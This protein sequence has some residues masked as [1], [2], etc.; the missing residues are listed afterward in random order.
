MISRKKFCCSPKRL[1]FELLK[2]PNILC[3][4]SVKVWKYRKLYPIL[5]EQETY[6][7][8]YI[9]Q[10]VPCLSNSVYWTLHQTIVKNSLSK[11]TRPRMIEHTD[12]HFRTHRNVAKRSWHFLPLRFV[13][14]YINYAMFYERVYV[15]AGRSSL[16]LF[17]ARCRW[18]R[19]EG[20]RHAKSWRGGKNEKLK[21]YRACNHLF[22]YWL[23]TYC[24]FCVK[25]RILLLNKP[26]APR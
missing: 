26:L 6:N 25:T 7:K 12:V 10:S 16:S 2:R 20:E 13:P 18:W 5:D 21:G 4:P 24:I 22:L 9:Q 8:V 1:I 23:I 19:P 17:Q 14:I 3:I 15:V 11:I